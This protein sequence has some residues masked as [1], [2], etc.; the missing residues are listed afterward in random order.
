MTCLQCPCPSSC[1]QRADFCAMAAKTPPDATELRHI[2][3][4]SRS[5]PAAPAH[6]PPAHV[7]IGNAVSAAGRAVS[8]LL[9]REPITVSPEE[10]ERRMALCRACDQ[11]RD[12]RCLRCGCNVN[13]KARLESETGQC[14]LKKW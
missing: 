1:L 3:E 2:C 5:G 14:P 11:Y 10:H 9:H 6:M 12:G 7:Q 8:Q 13:L 4:R